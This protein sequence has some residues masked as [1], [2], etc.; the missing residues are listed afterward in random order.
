MTLPIYDEEEVLNFIRM[1]LNPDVVLTDDDILDVV[2]AL[3]DFYDARGYTSLDD[4]DSDDDD[5]AEASDEEIADAL[6]RK[7]EKRM[8]Y[9]TMLTIIKAERDYEEDLD[10]SF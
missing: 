4:L 3:W 5:I 7:F 1:H 9:N 8:D 2:D 6:F 10:R